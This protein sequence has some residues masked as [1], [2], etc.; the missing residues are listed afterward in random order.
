MWRCVCVCVCVCA[1]EVA[2]LTV[3][4]Q[5]CHDFHQYKHLPAH[6]HLQK[7]GGITDPFSIYL[8]HSLSFTLFQNLNAY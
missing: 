8:M 6:G 3:I 1:G 5:T 4:N 7:L 2:S